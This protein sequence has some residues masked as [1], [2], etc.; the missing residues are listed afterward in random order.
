MWNREIHTGDI[1][2]WPTQ[3]LAFFVSLMLPMLS[4][5]GPLVWWTRRRKKSDLASRDDR[6]P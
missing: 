4:I 3:I 5:T 2:G 6:G 1:L